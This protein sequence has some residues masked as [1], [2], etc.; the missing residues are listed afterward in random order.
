MC[1]TYHNLLCQQLKELSFVQELSPQF[2]YCLFNLNTTHPII[3][4]TDNWN[5]N[6]VLFSQIVMVI[7]GKITARHYQNSVL[8]AMAT[9]S[10][11]PES[12]QVSCIHRIYFDLIKL[13]TSWCSLSWL[14][15]CRHF[16][17]DSEC[18]F[19]PC[20]R[21]IACPASVGKLPGAYSGTDHELL[22]SNMQVKLRKI[23][24]P[25]KI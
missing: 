21:T 10:F 2:G 8:V 23:V 22:M 9:N 19:A 11:L 20:F 5:Y 4:P 25:S 3:F 17:N 6:R 13:C 16:I 24:V 12:V 18:R 15:S 1:Q 7:Y 14:F